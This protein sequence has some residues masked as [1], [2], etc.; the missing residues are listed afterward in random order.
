M[1]CA[2][3]PHALHGL[4]NLRSLR[5]SGRSINDASL[6][7]LTSM[8]TLRLEDC[9]VTG[10][11]FQHMPH[12]AHLQVYNCPID[13]G[14]LRRVTG[15]KS[16]SMD[17]SGHHTEAL[18][19]MPELK[20]LVISRT[21]IPAALRLAHVETIILRRCTL[22]DDAFDG[23]VGLRQLSLVGC[24]INPAAFSRLT[25]ETHPNLHSV[26]V[27]LCQGVMREHLVSVAGFIKPLD[28]F[29]RVHPNDKGVRK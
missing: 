25:R 26:S 4:T 23:L 6:E 5:V 24:N 7:G 14:E 15:M 22:P 17:N 1:D 16:L 19:A 18:A 27:E 12:L 8:T 3:V 11:A 9:N 20:Q 28:F 13:T 21:T 29:F 10:R 2:L